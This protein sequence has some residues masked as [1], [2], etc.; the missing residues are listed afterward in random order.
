MPTTPLLHITLPD[1]DGPEHF[2]PLQIALEA[3]CK[4]NEWHIR[5]ALKKWKRGKGNP[6]IP[7]YASGVRYQEDPP[8]H[9]DWRDMYGV[10]KRGV[11]DCLPLSTLVLRDDYELVPMIELSPGDRIMGDAGWTSVIEHAVTGEKQILAFRLSNG[12]TLRCSPEHRVFRD[13]DGKVEEVRASEVKIGDDLVQPRS[14]PRPE[15]SNA[16]GPIMPASLDALSS[17]ER[18][19]LLGVYVADGWTQDST[20]GKPNRL[21]ISGLDG[22]P[23]EA[24]KRTVE[25]MMRRAGLS[26]RWNRKYIAINDRELAGFMATCG[27]RAQNKRLPSLRFASREDVCAVLEGLAADASYSGPGGEGSIVYGTTSPT[28]ALQLRVLYRMMGNSVSIRRVEDHGGFG[29]HAIYR[30]VPR[31]KIRE[32]TAERRDKIFARVREI[33]D[34]GVE[35]CCDITTES[36]KFWLPESDTIV[37]NCDQLVAWRVG[38]LRAGGIAAEPVLKWQ[39]ITRAQ[40]IST[41]YP[42]KML[43]ADG[44]WMVHCLVR[45]PDGRVEDPSKILGMGGSYT[46]KI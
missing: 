33:A 39:W 41:G 25:D 16:N 15:A 12:C 31:L 40:M 38:E 4:I 28:L 14:I 10:M 3:M 27:H 9:E 42:A 32:G 19:W 17:R 20:D 22:A 21:A 11:G 29:E 5:N 36:G 46:S 43:P 1:A 23:K 2:A 18:A 24:Q 34:G 30:I 7:L 6:P 8:G 45:Y 37:H 35:M 26:T 44:V 13:V